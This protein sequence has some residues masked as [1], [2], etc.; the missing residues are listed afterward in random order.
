MN[1]ILQMTPQE[2]TDVFMETAERKGLSDAI[3]EKDCW[4]TVQVC[5]RAKVKPLVLILPSC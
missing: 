5:W 4:V 3:V 1:K 2:R